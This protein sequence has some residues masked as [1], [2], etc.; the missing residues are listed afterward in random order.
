MND[1]PS[2]PGQYFVTRAI[3][4]IYKSLIRNSDDNVCIEIIQFR[5]RA[6]CTALPRKTLLEVSSFLFSFFSYDPLRHGA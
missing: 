1:E 6:A 2:D 5:P 4:V 3:K